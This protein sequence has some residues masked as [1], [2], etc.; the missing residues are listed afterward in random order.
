MSEALFEVRTHR[1]ENIRVRIPGSKSYTHRL[2][3]AAALADGPS[4]VSGCLRS[5]DTLL[6]AEALRQMGI[7]V[8]DHGDGRMDVEGRGGRLPGA[9][10]VVFLAN[11]GTSMRLLSAIAGLGEKTSTLDGNAR[12]RQ[13]P[14]GDLLDALGQVGIPARSLPETGCPP[15]VIGGG[16]RRGG[17]LSIACHLSSQYLS[18]L[19]LM[20]PCLEQGLDITVTRGPVSRPYIKMTL[21]ILKKM[22][23]SF[24]SE[25]DTRYRVPGGQTYRAGNYQVEPDASNASYFFA[26]AAVTGGSVCVEG[27]SLGSVQGDLGLLGIFE[28]M[29]CTVTS[30][31]HGICV[32]GGDLCSVDVDMGDMPDMVPT[33]AVVAAFAKGTSY[34]RNVAHL[35]EKECDRLSAVAT[36]LN[37]MGGSVRIVGDDLEIDGGCPLHGARIHTYDDHRMAMCFSVAGL[38]VPGVVIENPACVAKSFPNFFDVFARVMG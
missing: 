25:G 13:R 3:I 26:A 4:E 9:S 27:L 20:A 15:V 19:L 34:I 31:S 7:S 36:E 18:G 10:E 37:R 6:T 21:E 14:L 35:R 32:R 38:R 12:M 24:S 1:P 5:E 16:S 30:D 28:K 29:G 22:G 8:K 11:S 33:L 2:L 23:V 17:A